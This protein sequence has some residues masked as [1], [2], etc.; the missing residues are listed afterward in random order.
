MRSADLK[1][2][3]V[4]VAVRAESRLRTSAS[5]GLC[6]SDV[7]GVFGSIASCGWN[8]R[9]TRGARSQVLHSR[10]ALESG[11]PTGAGEPANRLAGPACGSS[12]IDGGNGNGERLPILRIHGARAFKWTDEGVRGSPTSTA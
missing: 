9:T 2:L 4:G 10:T 6:E 5:G 3:C 1:S 8:P 12:G 11:P 7:I